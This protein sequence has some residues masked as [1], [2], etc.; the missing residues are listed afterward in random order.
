MYKYITPLQLLIVTCI[1]IIIPSTASSKE[2][3][4]ECDV[5]E[6]HLHIKSCTSTVITC[7][8]S[9]IQANPGDT[10]TLTNSQ[11]SNFT[12]FELHVSQ[13][14]VFPKEIFLQLPMLQHLDLNGNT[15]KQIP[16]RAFEN[17]SSELAEI[18]LQFNQIRE[19]TAETFY[20][21]RSLLFLDLSTK[22][23]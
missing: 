20:G 11:E 21:L 22:R 12:S 4:A 3:P 1:C 15:L 2:I 6:Q 23:S 17:A 16:E 14:H 19:V 8:V 10:L 13:I 18:E 7:I 5:V 9:E